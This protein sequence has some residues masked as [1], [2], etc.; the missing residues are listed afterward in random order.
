MNTMLLQKLNDSPDGIIVERMTYNNIKDFDIKLPTIQRIQIDENVQEIV[1]HQLH[2]FQ[3]KKSFNYLGVININYCEEDNNWYLID[4]QHRFA[5]LKC[6]WE[7]CRQ[8]PCVFFQF[9]KTRTVDELKTNYET[10]NKN[11]PL[12]EFSAIIDKS[13]PERAYSIFKSKYPTMWAVGKRANRPHLNPTHFQTALGHITETLN[14]T[15][16]DT[17]IQFLTEWNELMAD[18][19]WTFPEQNTISQKMKEKCK[20]SGLYLGLYKH[21]NNSYVY[22]WVKQFLN[23]RK[24]SITPQ[25]QNPFDRD[26]YFKR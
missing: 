23:N 20:S 3:R 2:I 22:K 19:A 8:E 26:D 16:V 21:K 15:S 7:T 17:L 14:I 13:I 25:T 4:G 24:K 12:P 11:T 9:V 10:I 6:L 1:D 18:D 5:S